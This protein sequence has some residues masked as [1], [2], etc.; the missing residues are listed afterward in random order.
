MFA[1]MACFGVG[2]L[3][4]AISA[5]AGAISGTTLL[6]IMMCLATIFTM[7][8]VWE[9][10]GGWKPE[11]PEA[12]VDWM[13]SLGGP[14]LLVCGAAVGL[15]AAGHLTAVKVGKLAAVVLGSGALFGVFVLYAKKR[16]LLW[17]VLG[18]AILGILFGYPAGQVSQTLAHRAETDIPSVL[19]GTFFVTLVTLG[20]MK[21]VVKN[22]GIAQQ[23]AEWWP[24]AAAIAG[25][26]VSYAVGFGV[27]NLLGL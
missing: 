8:A 27:R 20:F 2:A 17:G 16:R 14:L 11:P 24:V 4:G 1:N 12:I 26:L 13:V 6:W 18:G 15:F 7:V 9:M 10:F 5:R 21:E 19:F 25:G 22:R 3:I 23:P